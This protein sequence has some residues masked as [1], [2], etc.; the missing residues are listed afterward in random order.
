MTD[1]PPNALRAIISNRI[2]QVLAIIAALLGIATEGIG[3]YRSYLAV[4]IETANRTKAEAD[5]AVAKAAA[6]GGSRP[7]DRRKI[8]E[9][10]EAGAFP[11]PLPPAK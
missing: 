7:I 9:A 5:A 4:G 11:D 2:F 3:L 6:E 8:N 10:Q 1:Q